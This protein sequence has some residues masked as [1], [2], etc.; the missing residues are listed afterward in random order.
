MQELDIASRYARALFECAKE[1][2]QAQVDDAAD[3]I[4]FISELMTQS[5]Q[6][7]KLLGN[8]DVT[9]DEKASLI[10]R[11]IGK[12]LSDLVKAFLRVVMEFGRS[13]TIDEIVKEFVEIIRK[14][15]NQVKVILK[16]ARP[17]P[18]ALLSR[19]KESVSRSEGK[20]LDLSIEI[21]EALLGGFELQ[22]EN[23][24]FDCSLRRQL[25]DLKENLITAKVN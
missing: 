11:L 25:K 9:A 21:D 17:V 19:I 8:L 13:D 20:E 14:E 15:R 18:D 5:P 7:K 10:S 1:S 4:S 6:L 3:E 12:D 23:R 24:V 2:G 16:S 22:I